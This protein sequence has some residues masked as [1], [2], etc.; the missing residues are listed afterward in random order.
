M[1]VVH[2]GDS[3]DRLAKRYL[4]DEARALEIFDLNRDVLANPHV[5]AIGIELRIPQ[6]T[7]PGHPGSGGSGVAL[8]SSLRSE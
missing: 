1:H 7:G 2:E 3:L 4:G 6:A 5:L 8:D